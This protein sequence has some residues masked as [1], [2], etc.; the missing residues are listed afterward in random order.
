M[1]TTIQTILS[2]ALALALGLSSQRSLMLL[3]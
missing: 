1:H 3:C 2:L